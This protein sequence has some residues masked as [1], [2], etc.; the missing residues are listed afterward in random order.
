MKE[1]YTIS[2][3]SEIYDIPKSKIRFWEKKNLLTPDRD[4]SNDYRQYNVKNIIELGDIVFFRSIGIPIKRLTEYTTMTHPQL[5]NIF[6][7]TRDD[8]D[9]EISRLIR[10][11]NALDV[12]IE[13]MNLI[14]NL[15][16]SPYDDSEPDFDTAIPFIFDKAKYG[17]LFQKNPYG[18]SLFFTFDPEI[19][20]IEAYVYQEPRS[21]NEPTVWEKKNARYKTALLK[22]NPNDMY[23]N[24]LNEHLAYF[25]AHHIKIDNVIA[26]YLSTHVDEK[27]YDFYQAWFQIA[28]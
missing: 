13:K 6:E 5:N 1:K 20:I 2:E 23:D 7:E 3:L 12:K 14:K 8:I 28:E 21:I 9:Q 10:T 25:K 22:M 24:N 19:K 18:Y 11:K 17:E 27:R 26:S 4:V 16:D 15:T